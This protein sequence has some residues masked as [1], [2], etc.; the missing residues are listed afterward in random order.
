M[1]I[2][3]LVTDGLFDTG[4][5]ALLDVFATANAFAAR[6]EA[7]APPFSVRL[8]SVRP[9][10]TTAHGL[11][12]P[13]VRARELDAIPDLVIVPALGAK[14]PEALTEALALREMKLAMS[15]LARWQQAGAQ[16][17]AA[18]TG[19]YL[20]ASA[21]LL[22]GRSA[23]TTWWL[24]PD[25]RARFPNVAL[26]DSRMI[27]ASPG[28][29]TAGAA[30]AHID[31]ALWLVRQR[32]PRVARTTA[33]HLLFDGRPSQAAFAM[34]DYLLHADPVVERFETFARRHLASF[35]MS[36]AARAVGTSERT[37]ERR[38]RTVLG[39]S[40][41]AYVRDLRV[42]EALHRLESSQQSIDEIAQAVGYQDGVTLRTLLRTKTGRGVRDLRQRLSER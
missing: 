39:R 35:S 32:S 3:V 25:F 5:S 34:P 22:D 21:G 4:L 19:T 11:Q 23:T 13:A 10:V 6:D 28:C 30:L 20:L 1:Q 41:I 2:S 7:S 9:R 12:V 24:A 31:L 36:D 37:L 40:P 29:T 26:D 16:L 14:T 18:C 38:V 27:V 17:A 15:W 33:H 8:V 42:E